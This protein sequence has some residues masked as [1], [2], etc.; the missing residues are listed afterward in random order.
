MDYRAMVR[1]QAE[2]YGLDPLLV[3]A[4]IYKESRYD[5]KAESKKSAIGLMQIMPDTARDIA[6][7]LEIEDFKQA[8]LYDAETNIRFGCYYFSKMKREF[9]SDTILA[10]AAYNSGPGNLREWLEKEGNS[11]ENLI[12]KYAFTETRRYVR[13]INKAYWLLRLCNKLIKI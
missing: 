6:R 11:S 4:I 2:E 3:A 13:D 12:E 9:N 10:L 8:D 7:D 1:K 5:E